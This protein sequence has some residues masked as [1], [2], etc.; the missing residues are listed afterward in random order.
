MG[1]TF[2]G[3]EVT[4]IG[5]AKVEQI[6][7]RA[8]TQYYSRTETFNGA[9]AKLIQSAADL[10]GADSPECLQTRRALQSVELDQPGYCSGLP[11]RP[12]AALDPVGW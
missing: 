1:G 8:M 9:Y 4:A 5:S 2:N 7:Y 12:P 6:W 3:S 10:Y 11:A